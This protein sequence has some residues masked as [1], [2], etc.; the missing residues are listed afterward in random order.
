MFLCFATNVSFFVDIHVRVLM[1][2]DATL[3][4]SVEIIMFW[5]FGV[6]CNHGVLHVLDQAFLW[7]FV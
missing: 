3:Q 4:L 5:C 1:C 2:L 7:L 6:L